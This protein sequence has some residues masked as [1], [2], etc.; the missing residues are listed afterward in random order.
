[1]P[2][3]LTSSSTS[4][5]VPV[6]MN[7]DLMISNI[8]T[9]R[10]SELIKQRIHEERIRLAT[11]LINSRETQHGFE[12]LRNNAKRRQ[13]EAERSQEIDNENLILLGKMRNIFLHGTAATNTGAPRAVEVEPR[14]L[15]HGARRRELERI[16]RE[17]LGIAER[18]RSSKPSYS[19][20][21]LLRGRSAHEQLVKR[22][23]RH[24]LRRSD[25][26]VDR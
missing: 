17:N 10:R 25:V 22:I 8:H 7:K 26:Y 3:S 9:E 4:I 21:A 12:H 23:S 1:M 13:M 16:T 2:R 11:P 14:S 15:N 5:R 24:G 20:E 6:G 18:I 19:A